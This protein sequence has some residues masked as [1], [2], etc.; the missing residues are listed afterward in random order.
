MEE[1]AESYRG[2]KNLS[3]RCFIEDCEF[4]PDRVMGSK[5][6]NIEEDGENGG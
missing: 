4:S 1:A 5:F 6:K 3:S 2:D